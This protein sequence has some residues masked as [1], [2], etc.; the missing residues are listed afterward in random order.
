LEEMTPLL[1]RIRTFQKRLELRLATHLAFR[2]INP[3]NI[4]DMVCSPV[5]YFPS[6][7]KFRPVSIKDCKSTEM[8]RGKTVLL[9]GGGLLGNDWFEPAVR[10]V[11][12]AAGVRLI[13]WGAGLNAYLKRESDPP[14][15]LNAF[16]LV[17]IRDYGVG[18]EWV[19]CASCMSPLFDRDYEVRHEVAIYDHPRLGKIGKVSGV[20]FLDNRQPDLEKAIGFL[21]SAETVVTSSY[22]G[23]YWATLLNRRVVIANPFSSKFYYL[24]HRHPVVS[25]E[26]W[27]VALCQGRSYPEALS[28]CRQANLRFHE[29][30]VEYLSRG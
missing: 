22:H 23:A 26:E 18:Y 28:E 12:G 15:Y 1:G 4:G 24:K 16:G 13:C 14:D 25:A 21:G 9:G 20:P 10:N 19:P 3:N 7:R 2:W 30:V 6:L 17:G 27:R 11:I 8:C 5:D 29:K